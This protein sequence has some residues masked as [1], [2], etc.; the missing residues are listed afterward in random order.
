M[1][2]KKKN[3]PKRKGEF[4]QNQQ[5]TVTPPEEG[6]FGARPSIKN[7]GSSNAFGGENTAENAPLSNGVRWEAGPKGDLRFTRGEPCTDGGGI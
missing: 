3:S 2:E 7:A 1:R 4:V 6:R 5:C